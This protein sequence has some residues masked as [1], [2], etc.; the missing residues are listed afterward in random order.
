[1]KV[2]KICI[3]TWV[4]ASH[5]KRELSAIRE[6]GHE[7]E[8]LAKGEESGKIEEVDGFQVTR[9]SSRPLGNKIPN[10]INRAVSMFTWSSYV[11]K[12]NDIDV[13]SGHDYLALTIGW[14]SNIFKKKKA[15]LVYDSHEFELERNSNR[16]KLTLWWIC[17]L[18]RFLMKRCE[19]SLMV[20]DSIADEIQQLHNL[21]GRPVVVRNTPSYWTLDETKIA[22]TRQDILEHLNLPQETFLIM[23]HGF[24]RRENGLEQVLQAVSQIP[25]TAAVVVGNEQPESKGFFP[26]MA[27]DLGIESRTYFHPA[28]PLQELYRFVGAA[29]IGFVLL[30][31]FSKNALYA[32]PNKLFENIQSLTPIVASNFPEMGRIVTDYRIGLT[33]DPSNIEECVLAAR[34]L[35]EDTDLYNTCKENLKKAKAELCWEKEKQTLQEAYRRILL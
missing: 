21:K 11:R 29:N 12:R 13:I 31:P 30:P 14:M 34:R 8:V 7:V 6:M 18:E 25:G 4:N 23:F 33:A 1:M 5:D 26:K 10:A 15:K 9:M 20:S 17:H 2:L 35:K 24:W 22:Q 27:K 3:G 28:V 16:N 19:F 32:L